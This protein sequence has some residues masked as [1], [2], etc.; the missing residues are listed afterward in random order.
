MQEIDAWN[1]QKRTQWKLKEYTAF[2]SEYK[3][4]L[5]GDRALWWSIFLPCKRLGQF[6][7]T[8]EK[9]TITTKPQASVFYNEK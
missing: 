1:C 4:C 3:A 5:A 7:A 8:K 6:L 2:K 9:R